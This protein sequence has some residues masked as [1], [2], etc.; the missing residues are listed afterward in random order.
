MN[1]SSSDEQ[2]KAAIRK[3][4]KCPAYDHEDAGQKNDLLAAKDAGQSSSEN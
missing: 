2:W 3:S 1:E 4:N